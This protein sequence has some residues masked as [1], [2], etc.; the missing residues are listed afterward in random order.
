M[1][2]KPVS[3]QRRWQLRRQAEGKCIK[4]GQPRGID[5]T[6]EHCRFHANQ[7]SKNSAAAKKAL[8]ARIALETK[9][10]SS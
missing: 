9:A 4:C 2:T 3:P 7:H 8:A 6:N 1:T 5:G 10:A